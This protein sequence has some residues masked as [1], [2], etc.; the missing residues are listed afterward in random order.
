MPSVEDPGPELLSSLFGLA[1]RTALVTGASAGLGLRFAKVLHAAGA[2][3]VPV[4]RRLDRLEEHFGGDERYLPLACDVRS[5][6]DRARVVQSAIDAYGSV[7]VLVNNAGIGA[8]AVAEEADLVERF[9]EVIE[10]DL[11]A[12]YALCELVAE[13][14]RSRGGG[15]IIN[16]SSV[17]GIV[18]AAPLDDVAYCAAKGGVVNLTRQLGARWIRRG[19]RVN[20]IAPGFFSTD[21]SES[22]VGTDKARAFI[23]DQCPIGRLGEV[24]EL[25]AALL[26]LAGAGSSYVT[27]QVLV[28]DGGWTAR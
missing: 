23:R 16:I 11:L 2:N 28:V 13:P 27:G 12:L 21:I 20:S 9:R 7:D 15:S 4:A 22:T 24:P 5:A 18:A 14:M 19:I 26:F 10:V 6:H 8:Q 17:F 25:D 3:V 1:G